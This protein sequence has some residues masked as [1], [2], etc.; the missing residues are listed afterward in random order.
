ML[1]FTVAI[2]VAVAL[3]TGGSSALVSALPRLLIGAVASI[4]SIVTGSRTG[5]LRT[6]TGIVSAV[7]ALV[8]LVSLGVTLYQGIAGDEALLALLP[9][10]IAVASS[11][12]AA[13]KT[14]LVALRRS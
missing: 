10:A 4:L 12:L 8:A 1:A 5:P 2:G 14:T 11:L 3:L 7:T 13:V 6:I 9:T